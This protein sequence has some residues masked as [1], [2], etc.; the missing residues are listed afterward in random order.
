MMT[1]RNTTRPR[2]AGLDIET[3]TDPKER[4]RLQNRIA[5]RNSRELSPHRSTVSNKRNSQW[6]CGGNTCRLTFHLAPG[7]R[8]AATKRE[9][10]RLDGDSSP[11]TACL[12]QIHGCNTSSR[13]AEHSSSKSPEGTADDLD[14]ARVEAETSQYISSTLI[15]PLSLTCGAFLVC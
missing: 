3:V 4:R 2:P 12:C 11:G 5:Q 8:R 9:K 14:L 6:H 15:S 13:P 10:I 7:R 1:T